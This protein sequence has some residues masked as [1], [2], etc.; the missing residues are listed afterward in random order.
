MT[1]KED[2]KSY[3]LKEIKEMRKKGLGKTDPNAPTHEVD[4]NF[5][6]NATVV[7]PS[8]HTKLHL[9]I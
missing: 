1:Q 7:F 2:I 8:S 3:S 6:K 5:W 9:N 4:E